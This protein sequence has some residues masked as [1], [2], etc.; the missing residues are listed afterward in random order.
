MRAGYR[1]FPISPRNSDRGVANLLQ[2]MQV[3]HLIVSK[4]DMAQRTIKAACQ[5]L[6]DDQSLLNITLL[7]AP[8]F[9]ELFSRQGNR[10]VALPPTQGVR[11]DDVALILH[12]SGIK[13][14]HSN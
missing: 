2:K 11:V 3:R 1:A 4:D 9:D 6:Q 13:F 10:F 7:E 12:S 14:H 5:L 8:T